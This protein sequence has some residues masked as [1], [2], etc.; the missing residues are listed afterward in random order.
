[1][2]RVILLLASI[3]ISSLNADF[4]NI[5]YIIGIDLGST[6][7]CACVYKNGHVELITKI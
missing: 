4:E 1:M 2:L 7:S 5:E 3:F 6:T